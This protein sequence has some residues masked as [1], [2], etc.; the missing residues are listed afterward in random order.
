MH[1]KRTPHRPRVIITK[2]ILDDFFTNIL[3]G[4]M[5]EFA[6]QK[7]LSYALI[8][9]LARGRVRSLSAAHFE[10]IFGRKPPQQDSGRVDGTYFREMVIL[11]LF[12]NNGITQKKLYRELYPQKRVRKEDYRIFTGEIDTPG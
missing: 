8:Y 7:G 12:L 3:T 9:N 2:D 11:W 4:E 10:V 6:S 5:S 1:L